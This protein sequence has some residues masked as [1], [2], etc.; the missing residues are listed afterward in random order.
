LTAITEYLITIGTQDLGNGLVGITGGPDGNVYFTDTLNN[1]IGQITPSG[2]ISEFPLPGPVGG[3]VFKNGLDGITL[4]ANDTLEFTEA[5]QGALGNISTTGSYTQVPI[6]STGN[7]TGQEP[8]QI[9]S[10]SDG[11]LWFAEDA[12][13]AIGELTP[14]GAFY[15]YPVPNA[16]NGGIIGAS[17]KGITIGPDGDVWFTNW[18]SSGD[19]I[20][21]ITPAG[22]VLEYSLPFGTDPVG[23]ATGPDGNLWFTAYGSNTIDVMSTSGT[24]L[25]QY[26]VPG[27]L[28]NDITAGPDGNLYFTEETGDIGEITPGGVATNTPVS[29][30][31]PTHPGASGPQPLAITSGP[32]GNIWFTDPWTDSIGVLRIGTA[33]SA[34]PTMTAVSASPNGGQSFTIAATVSDLS[35]GGAV[36]NGGTVTFSDQIGVIDTATLVNGTAAFTTSSLPAGTDTITAFYAGTTVFAPSSTGRIV[37][38]AGNGTGAYDGDGAAATAAELNQPCGL[39]VDSAGDLFI[40]DYANNVVRE[41]IK[42][43]GDIITVAGNGTPGSGGDGGLAV[44]AEL[45]FPEGVAVDSAGNVFIADT[46]NNQVREV[47]KATGEIVTVA[48]SGAVGPAADVPLNNPLAVAVDAAG[49]LF[50]ADWG[51]NVIREVDLATG[52]ISTVAGTGVPGF[53]GN[54]G[55]ATAAKLD[56]PEGIAVDSAGDLFI[57]DWKNNVVREVVKATGQIIA[58]AGNHTAGHSGDNGPATAAE[59]DQ[60]VGLALDSAGDLFIAEYG[61]DAVREVVKASGDIITVAGNL[62]S[63]YSGDG[64]LA[65]AAELDYPFG[66]AVNSAGELFV[67]DVNNNVVREVTPAATVEDP[68]ALPTLTALMA[69]TTSAAT[70]QSVTFTATVSDLYPG[71]TTPT[72]GMVTF[73]DQGGVIG[74]QAL[75]NG[76][77][78]FK[79]SSLPAGT[80]TITASYGGTP[81]FAP[82]SAV[83]T[84]TV[85]KGIGPPSKLV[86]QTQ[87][88]ATATAGQAFA[89]QPV[90]DVE[91]ASGNL[92]VD[93]NSTVVSVALASAKGLPEGTTSVTVKDGVATFAGLNETTAGIIALV[94]S[95]DGLSSGPS[96]NITVSPGAPFR[97]AIATQ[98]SP[99]AAPGQAFATQPVIDE[100][101]LYGNLETTE[102]GTLITAAVTFGNGPLVGT[103]TAALVGGVATFTNLADNYVGTIALG[104]SGGGL[105]VGPSNS[106]VISPRIGA[107]VAPTLSIEPVKP[108][109]V[110]NAKGKPTGKTALAFSFKYSTTM[111]E[112]SANSRTNY[113]VEAAITKPTTKKTTTKYK[114]VSSF[115]VVFNAQTNTVTLTVS[116]N[117]RF[118]YGGKILINTGVASA[119]GVPLNSNDAE[120]S[121]AARAKSLMIG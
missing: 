74:S 20:G 117:Q 77:A 3:G 15:Q 110:L 92:E 97:L 69:S 106:I 34:L 14:A 55:P 104:F 63:G 84:V 24:I 27:G 48:G 19:F 61:D 105:S 102:S 95:G 66:L 81:D 4:G 56:E 101:D 60:P 94:F 88:S 107:A 9:T 54:N 21:T 80:D 36:P 87:P 17:M 50:I 82:S 51:N 113:Q 83:T 41:V 12:A 26:S 45:D 118:T 33:P 91:D 111:N 100:L 28:L 58:F 119:S 22:Q 103:T 112:E 86:I 64:G 89:V 121:I 8:D 16:T 35:A 7:N 65:T 18:G 73:S 13:K 29:T 5:A 10:T 2:V 62:T 93:D 57:A 39:A 25:E 75:V 98:P 23:I 47:V 44:N 85:E 115:T 109:K 90:I 96:G 59:L 52:A 71:E 6:D 46:V 43:T 32:D 72:G 42:T 70:G 114:S 76:T 78:A 31:V 67:S 1:A 108:M 11:T 53:S 49:D 120:L 30:T 38:A 68:S 37:T 116:G 40:A 79:T 99:T